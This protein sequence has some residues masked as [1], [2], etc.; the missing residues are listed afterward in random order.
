LQV[1]LERAYWSTKRSFA[2]V[3]SSFSLKVFNGA[4]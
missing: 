4:K 2:R 1:R 3:I